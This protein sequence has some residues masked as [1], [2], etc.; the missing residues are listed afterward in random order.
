MNKAFL[1]VVSVSLFV[2]LLLISQAFTGEGEWTSLEIPEF[3]NVS[4]LA[5]DST[6]TTIY[7]TTYSDGY[8]AFQSIDGGG[9]WRDITD[10][11]PPQSYFAAI[12][13]DPVNPDIAYVGLSD[14]GWHLFI[15]KTTDRGST[16][17]DFSDG[18]PIGAAPIETIVIDP[19]HPD[20]LYTAIDCAGVY[21]STDGGQNWYPKVNGLFCRHVEFIAIDPTNTEIIYAGSRGYNP[22]YGEVFKSV[23]G[24]E[25]W[26]EVDSG[27]PPPC[28]NADTCRNDIPALTIDPIHPLILY[29]GVRV[30]GEEYP[31]RTNIYKTIN[32]AISWAKADSGLPLVPPHICLAVDPRHSDN[33]YIG[34]RLGDWEGESI[35]R[36]TNGGQSWEGFSNGLPDGIGIAHLKVLSTKPT[37]IYAGTFQNLWV[38]TDTLD[39]V[40]DLPDDAHLPGQYEL[41]QNHP[42]PFNPMTE[43]KYA[44]PRNCRVKLEVYNILGQ[45]VRTLVD[46]EQAAGY[47]MVSWDSRGRSGNEVASG[48]YFYQLRAGDFV[49][50]RK[51]VL[52]K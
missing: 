11:F 30:C 23:D 52:L 20:T 33:V 27:I 29:V 8:K 19:L 44:L 26:F 51:M 5:T 46:E 38:Y 34:F 7:A 35:Y 47:R 41:F 13:I 16:W 1:R 37:K 36:T 3:N 28:V 14:S 31:C 48:I 50:T 4:C 12:A 22:C 24:A 32:G 42:N 10:K 40:K 6:G 17:M 18:L 9:T 43:I 39:S 2:P 15:Y 45:R 21:K 25:S 49:Q